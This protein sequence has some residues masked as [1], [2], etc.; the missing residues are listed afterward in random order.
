MTSVNYNSG[1]GDCLSDLA[2]I[3]IITHDTFGPMGCQLPPVVPR[4][5]RLVI[6][7]HFVNVRQPITP[8]RMDDGDHFQSPI[9]CNI[10][11]R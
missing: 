2:G 10:V 4:R 7:N 8:V 3:V 9:L 1:S 6:I 5:V 11:D